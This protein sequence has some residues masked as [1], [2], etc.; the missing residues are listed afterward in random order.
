MV[1]SDPLVIFIVCYIP[2]RVL[3]TCPEKKKKK[4]ALLGRWRKLIHLTR[5]KKSNFETIKSCR[6]V[7]APT[8]IRKKTRLSRSEP[9]IFIWI[10]THLLVSLQRKKKEREREREVWA[11]RVRVPSTLPSTRPCSF[12][13][14][15]CAGVSA[16]GR[17]CVWVC[18]C[19]WSCVCQ[20]VCGRV[21][22]R[23]HVF[24][25]EINMYYM[26]GWYYWVAFRCLIQLDRISDSL[27]ESESELRI[28]CLELK[29]AFFVI[30][31]FSGQLSNTPPPSSVQ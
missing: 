18:M 8:P 28:N 7:T 11:H 27:T 21:R 16:C 1:P 13:V 12:L 10:I 15:T 9:F 3:K 4:N 31:S 17:L 24:V 14:C 5:G 6:K 20:C 26:S 19:V 30:K 23:A 2:E 22:A 29:A 25:F